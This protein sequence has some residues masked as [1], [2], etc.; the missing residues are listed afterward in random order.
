MCSR[1]FQLQNARIRLDGT[2]LAKVPEYSTVRQSACEWAEANRMGTLR[3]THGARVA[4]RDLTGAEAPILCYDC[5]PGLKSGASTDVPSL[6]MTGGRSFRRAGARPGGAEPPSPHRH[7]TGWDRA[8]AEAPIL[9]YDCFPGLKSG[10]STMRARS[11]VGDSGELRSPGRGGAPSPHGQCT[12]RSPVPTRH[13]TLRSPVPTRTLH[14]AELRPPDT[15][16]GF[17]PAL[18]GAS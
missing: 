14:G 18:E 6:G 5:F 4:A 7:C 15:G 12:G 2:E 9:C 17:W 1:S 10:A 16:R 13:C 8:G 11:E 3:M